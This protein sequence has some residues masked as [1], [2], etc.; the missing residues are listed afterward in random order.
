MIDNYFQN[1]NE[2][3]NVWRSLVNHLSIIKI[4]IGMK[5]EM[6]TNHC[7]ITTSHRLGPVGRLM[8][9]V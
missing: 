8:S 4:G 7:P 1:R 6:F 9:S 3:G 5:M 2:N